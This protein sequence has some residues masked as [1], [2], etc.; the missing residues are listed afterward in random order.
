MKN[1]ASA[2]SPRLL[3]LLSGCATVPMAPADLDARAMM[4]G[5][6]EAQRKGT[7][8]LVGVETASLPGFVLHRLPAKPSMTCGRFDAEARQTLM[9]Q[10][11]TDTV[12]GRGRAMRER[13]QAG[14]R[15]QR[16]IP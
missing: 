11:T 14:C 16:G 7:D 15:G 13:A 9:E 12:F 1:L 6:S 8:Q 10:M 5:D 2:L 3:I 4:S